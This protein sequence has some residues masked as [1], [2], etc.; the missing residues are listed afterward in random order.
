[1]LEG[2][3]GTFS[4]L[5]VAPLATKTPQDF[6]AL[7]VDPVDGPGVAGGDEQVAVGLH[8]NGVDVEVVVEIGRIRGGET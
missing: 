1:V 7:A 3:P 2:G 6:P 4:H 8:V 5:E